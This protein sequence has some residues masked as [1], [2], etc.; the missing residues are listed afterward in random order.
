MCGGEAIVE[1][2]FDFWRTP[3]PGPAARATADFTATPTGLKRCA[4]GWMPLVVLGGVCCDHVVSS[5]QALHEAL[6]LGGVCC[7]RVV[8]CL[9]ALHEALILL[10]IGHPSILKLK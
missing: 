5:L 10:S 4:P 8:S 3:R 7:A 6:I 2:T 1:H 9:Q